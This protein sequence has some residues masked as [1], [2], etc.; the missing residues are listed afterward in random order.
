MVTGKIFK[1]HHLYK[2]WIEDGAKEEYKG[3]GYYY[4]DDFYLTFNHPENVAQAASET[5]QDIYDVGHHKVLERINMDRRNLT[6]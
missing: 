4:D 3:E 2:K 5:S 6:K 1:E